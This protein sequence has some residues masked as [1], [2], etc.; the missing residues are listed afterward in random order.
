MKKSSSKTSKP[1]QNW[2][3][4]EQQTAKT[5]KTYILCMKLEMKTESSEIKGKYCYTF[6]QIA[7][8]FFF[9][10]Y[11]LSIQFSPLHVTLDFCI[12]TRFSI[13][14]LSFACWSPL[15]K[16]ILFS[17]FLSSS[18]FLRILWFFSFVLLLVVCGYLSKTHFL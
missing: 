3:V 14:F 12:W 6:H 7:T 2:M 16:Q 15:F 8:C 1:I 11:F 5:I 18:Y 17:H 13:F 10:C 4:C 9:G